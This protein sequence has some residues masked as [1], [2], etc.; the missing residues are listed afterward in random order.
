[1]ESHRVAGNA[2][3]IQQMLVAPQLLGVAVQ[4]YLYQALK[5]M[6]FVI[7]VALFMVFIN[8]FVLF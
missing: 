4:A 5:L 6:G 7:A 3:D 2:V 1:M 8:I